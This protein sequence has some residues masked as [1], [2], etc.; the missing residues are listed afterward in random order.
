MKWINELLFPL[1]M[2]GLT[3]KTPKPFP[4]I[5][6]LIRVIDFKSNNEEEE[7][8]LGKKLKTDLK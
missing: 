8:F 3:M 4:K 2:K 6:I 5:I 7:N 1:V